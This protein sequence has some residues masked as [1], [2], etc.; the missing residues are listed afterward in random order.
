MLRLSHKNQEFCKSQA[1]KLKSVKSVAEISSLKDQPKRIIYWKC[2]LNPDPSDKYNHHQT[3][4]QFALTH[5]WYTYIAVPL[6]ILTRLRLFIYHMDCG[7]HCYNSLLPEPTIMR[8][9]CDNRIGCAHPRIY[10]SSSTHFACMCCAHKSKRLPNL[11][12]L[13]PSTAVFDY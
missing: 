2:T 11:S 8:I 12:P 9:S 4:Y 7:Q 5:Y 3:K 10:I 6:A 13:T 1:S